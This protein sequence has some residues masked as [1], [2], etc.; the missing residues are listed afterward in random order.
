MSASPA[1]SWAVNILRVLAEGSYGEGGVLLTG[2]QAENVRAAY[3]AYWSALGQPH[4]DLHRSLA[5]ALYSSETIRIG[6]VQ[7]AIAVLPGEA[8]LLGPTS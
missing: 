8:G 1:S 4:S 3:Y 2:E 5:I 7:P 6:A